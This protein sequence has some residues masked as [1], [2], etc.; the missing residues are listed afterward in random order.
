MF[1]PCQPDDFG[2]GVLLAAGELRNALPG[3]RLALAVR[4]GDGD[5]HKAPVA[6]LHTWGAIDSLTALATSGQTVLGI[7]QSPFG[8]AGRSAVPGSHSLNTERRKSG[9]A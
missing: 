7:R 2:V 1:S 4:A 9:R 6:S 3:A 5:D 8:S